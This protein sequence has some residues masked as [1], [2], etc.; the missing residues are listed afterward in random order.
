MMQLPRKRTAKKILRWKVNTPGLLSEIMN[1]SGAS[2]L[3]IPLH[4]FADLLMQ[5]AKRASE[6][7]DP[8]LNILMLRLALYE[9]GDPNS[10]EYNPRVLTELE[11]EVYGVEGKG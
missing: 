1:N 3:R 4:I 9:A 5:V 2:V 6:I 10:S 8:K 7:N 11:K